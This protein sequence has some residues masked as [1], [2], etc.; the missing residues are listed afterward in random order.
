MTP[1]CFRRAWDQGANRSAWDRV[2]DTAWAAPLAGGAV[3]VVAELLAAATGAL[4]PGRWAVV[5]VCAAGLRGDLLQPALRKVHDERVTARPA[6]ALP[7]RPIPAPVGL[8]GEQAGEVAP[9]AG[10]HG[11]RADLATPYGPPRTDSP[12][13]GSAERV[14]LEGALL[15]ADRLARGVQGDDPVQLGAGGEGGGHEGDPGDGLLAAEGRHRHGGLAGQLHSDGGRVLA[16]QPGQQQ[17]GAGQPRQA[18]HLRV[19]AVAVDV[20]GLQLL[21]VP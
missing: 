6:A 4:G 17:A 21:P 20:L 12:G 5:R 8:A 14:A 10:R 9:L 16:G 2:L 3:A 11:G 19:D 18:V 1:P 13:L 7:G 15:G